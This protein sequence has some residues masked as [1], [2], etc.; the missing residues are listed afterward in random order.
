MA[1]KSL[2]L[3]LYHPEEASEALRRGPSGGIWQRSFES[4]PSDS[5]LCSDVKVMIH[6][7]LGFLS[8]AL[9]KTL[10]NQR[11][12]QGDREASHSILLHT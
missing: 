3:H 9:V 5:T 1:D 8:S 11:V 6:N 10:G 7:E 12:A 2:L 4:W